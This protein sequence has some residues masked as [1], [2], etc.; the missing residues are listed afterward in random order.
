MG[1]ISS[2]SRLTTSESSGGFPPWASNV[3]YYDPREIHVRE[4]LFI[5]IGVMLGLVTLVFILMAIFSRLRRRLAKRI[6][7]R[8]PDV[9]LLALHLSANFVGQR[10]GSALRGNGALLLSP[11]MLRFL[12]AVPDREIAIPLTSVRE[13]KL[14][15]A[16]MQR[17]A[18]GH[19][20]L[21]IVHREDEQERETG[22][23]LKNGARWKAAID[24]ACQILAEA[25][26]TD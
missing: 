22:F 7:E 3:Y 24:Q 9:E 12:M 21:V 26:L 11:D 18:P 10:G 15:R 2:S 17:S 5:S 6:R 4:V 25:P 16:F 13:V 1:R 19:P 14:E 8:Y 20:V 23:L